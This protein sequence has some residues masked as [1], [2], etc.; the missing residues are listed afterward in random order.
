M[1]VRLGGGV[2]AAAMMAGC[3]GGGFGGP[4][5]LPQL[6]TEYQANET[7]VL[8]QQ[9]PRVARNAA[10]QAMVVWE[11]LQQ[12]GGYFDIHARRFVDGE[13]VGSEFKVNSTTAGRQNFGAVA[14]DAV[15][16]SVVV[17]RSSLQDGPGGTIY[18]QR[19]AADGSRVGGEFQIGPSSSDFDSQS[20]PRVA[21]NAAGRFAVVWSNREITQLAI[22]L[23]RNDIE[24]RMVQVRVFDPDGSPVTDIVDVVGPTTAATVRAPDIGIADDGRFAVTW[25]S[26]GSP[27]GIRVRSFAADGSPTSGDTQVDITRNEAAPDFPALSMNAA[28]R[29]VVVWEAMTFGYQ[30]LGVFGRLYEGDADSPLGPERLL[31]APALGLLERVSV[32]LSADGRF[33]LAGSGDDAVSVASFGADGTLGRFSKLSNAGFASLFGAVA[34]ASDGRATVTWNSLGQDG[35]GRG[36]FV[37][38]VSVE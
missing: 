29:F 2:L 32:S 3:G 6:G 12:D 16:N 15:G 25:I 5:G 1:S 19:F 33:A 9:R 8:D 22:L 18:G 13:P 21:M 31:S 11:S 26:S 34:L 30:P 4:S 38:D 14:L 37:R 20:E 28:G 17:W 24:Q 10:G 35:D 36:V 23:G 7:T 27:N